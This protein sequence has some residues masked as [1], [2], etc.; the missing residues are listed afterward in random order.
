L[1]VDVYALQDFA[2]AFA[3]AV[4]EWV[5]DELEEISLEIDES[6]RPPDEPGE[7]AYLIRREDDVWHMRYLG[8]E[9]AHFVHSV[10][11]DVIARL[12]RSPGR[13]IDGFELQG[14]AIRAGQEMLGKKMDGSDELI[15]AEARSEDDE[16]RGRQVGRRQKAADRDAIKAVKAEVEDLRLRI[17]AAKENNLRVDAIE[18]LEADLK[19]GEHWLRGRHNTLGPPPET[20]TAYRTARTYIQRAF[21][22]IRPKMPRFAEY[23][24]EKIQ[25]VPDKHKW[26][27]RP[28]EDICWATS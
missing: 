12:L 28:G 14:L 9:D 19:K 21:R 17:D 3:E 6:N 11:F 25:P 5:P 7:P 18:K 16:E 23:L 4:R 8:I 2:A 20:I 15:V 27:Y 24:E 13:E 10:I 26:V 1:P 22:E